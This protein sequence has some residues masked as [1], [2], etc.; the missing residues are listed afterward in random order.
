MLGSDKLMAFVATADAERCKTFYRDV[1]GLKLVADETFALVFDVRGAMLRIQKTNR[2]DPQPFTAL[3]WE[4]PDIAARVTALNAKGVTCERYPNMPQDEL[5]IW[6]APE[7]AKVAWFR[8]PD[9]NLLSLT[10]F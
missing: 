8:D 10:Q 2:V 7:G 6:A 5:G 4:V 1:L 9:G 3:G